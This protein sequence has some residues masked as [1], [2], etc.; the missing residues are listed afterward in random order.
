MAGTYGLYWLFLVTHCKYG[1]KTHNRQFS[2]I[3]MFCSHENRAS[4]TN[5]LYLYLK[6]LFDVLNL[7]VILG[8]VTS[9]LQ[10][11]CFCKPHN[12]VN[13]Q[14]NLWKYLATG[15]MVLIINY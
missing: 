13:L 1:I 14:G 3:V 2:A 10:I 15:I 5:V 7:T 9:V 12:K 11:T 8:I 6:M 4:P